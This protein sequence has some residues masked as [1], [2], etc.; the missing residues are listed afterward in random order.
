MAKVA[1]IGGGIA[2]LTAAF[3]LRERNPNIEI[4]IFE[5]GERCGGKVR[6]EL[7]QASSEKF[8]IENGPNGFLDNQPAT[9]DFVTKL[10]LADRVIAAS[11]DAK[12]RYIYLRGKLRKAPG[13]PPEFIKSD[14]LSFFGKLRVAREWFIKKATVEVAARESVAAFVRRR[15]GKEVLHSMVEPFA[16]GVFAGDIEKLELV[17]AFPRLAECEQQY[18]GLLRTLISMEREKKNLSKLGTPKPL[19]TMLSFRSGMGEL[20][21]ALEQSLQKNIYIHS[22]VISIQPMLGRWNVTVEKDNRKEGV[23]CEAVVLAAPAPVAA[24]FVKSWCP[25]AANDLLTIESVPIAVVALGYDDPAARPKEFDGFGFLVARGEKLRILGALAETS[26]FERGGGG[27]LTR[28]MIG[29]ARAPELLNCTDEELVSIAREDLQTATG[30]RA[31]PNIS[32]VVRWAA[33]IP[34]YTIGHAARI[35]R[36]EAA[37]GQLPNLILAGASYHGVSINDICKNALQ[38]ARTFVR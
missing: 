38:I 28:V 7:V 29:G 31:A 24:G 23:L 18:G 9:L 19:T 27:F 22:R 30:L 26:I 15:F 25:D 13:S 21:S 33:A 11:P 4:V 10:G 3:A 8:L 17:S 32:K 1:V 6:T 20:V 16:T 37:L 35:A 12:R 34:Q 2:G 5:S 14:I 36:I